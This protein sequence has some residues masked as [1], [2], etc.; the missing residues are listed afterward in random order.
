MSNATTIKKYGH[1]KANCWFRNNLFSKGANA[2]G[3]NVVAE[4]EDEG[5]PSNL[6][7]VNNKSNC[8]SGLVWSVDSSCSNH[9]S[10]TR[11]IFQNLDDILN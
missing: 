3:A 2:S 1:I 8:P 9:L 5:E 4:N 7:V 11:K 10:G 6:F